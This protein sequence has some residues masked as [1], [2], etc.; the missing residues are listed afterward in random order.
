MKKSFLAAIVISL[1]LLVSSGQA[2]ASMADATAT[3]NI[4]N[5]NNISPFFTWSLNSPGTVAYAT[6]FTTGQTDPGTT[7]SHAIATGAASATA[8][9]GST[10][11][12]A[13]SHAENS[14][15]NAT[16][17]EA[18]TNVQ[19]SFKY[20]GTSNLDVYIALPYTLYYK[21]TASPGV[22]FVDDS[23]ATGYSGVLFDLITSNGDYSLHKDLNVSPEA[24][25][26]V[27]LTL[28]QNKN[29]YIDFTLHPGDSGTFTIATNTNTSAAAAVPVPAAFW[30]LGSGLVGLAGVRR[31]KMSK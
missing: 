8:S 27:S 18:T 3:L 28:P 12:S 30:L 20:T 19:G 31:R 17:S 21:L 7:Y 16:L 15:E 6:N 10:F 24:Y 14:G 2:L 25:D 23:Y 5:L 1:M 29:I 9:V 4:I 26:G 11:F 13:V 22:P